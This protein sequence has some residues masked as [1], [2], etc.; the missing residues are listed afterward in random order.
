[1]LPITEKHVLEQLQKIK[2]FKSGLQL[3]EIKE[4]EEAKK[5]EIH[6]ENK[7]NRS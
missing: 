4:P 3:E 2:L 5:V 6:R 7:F 1:M